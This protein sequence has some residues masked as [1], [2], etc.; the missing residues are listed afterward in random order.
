MTRLVFSPRALSDLERLVDFLRENDPQAAAETLDL[1]IDGL[2]IL[3]AHPL[4]GRPAEAGLREVVVSRGRSGYLALYR[5]LATHDTALVLAIRH[6]SE[7]GYPHYW[8]D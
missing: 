6:Q 4:V 8:G 1:L 5:F 3:K 7:G 2:E